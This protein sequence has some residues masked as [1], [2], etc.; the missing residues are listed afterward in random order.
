MA[1]FRR[2]IQT[3]S[4]SAPPG[5]APRTITT[6]AAGRGIA[7]VDAVLIPVRCNTWPG[8][9]ERV[10]AGATEGGARG[11]AFDAP[12]RLQIDQLGDTL[13]VIARVPERELRR[14]GA[15]EVQVQ[16][17]LPR[18]ADA[19]V[20]LDAGAGRAA[21]GVGDVGL[22]LGA[23]RRPSRTFS[24]TPPRA[25]IGRDLPFLTSTRQSA[26]RVLPP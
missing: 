4:G 10:G 24:V 25:E 2:I 12:P 19:A 17:V 21:I 7:G 5:G 18:E 23:A 26:A 11:G 3:S 14:L 9:D 1:F 13:A 22:A 16:V 8:P 6:E 15:L 20:Q